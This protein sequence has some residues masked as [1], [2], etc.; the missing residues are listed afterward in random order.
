MPQPAFVAAVDFGGTKMAVAGATLNGEIIDQRRLKTQ[1]ARGAEQ[2]VE[3][4][5]EA[6]RAVIEH[7]HRNTGGR[8]VSLG[9]VCPGIVRSD[10][11]MLA[12][13][14]PGWE[15]LA[16]A[17]IMREALGIECVAVCNDV[18]AA[19]LAEL[20]WGALAGADPALFVSL[21][22]GVAA[23]VLVGGRILH[24]AH[25]AAGEI[26]YSLRCVDDAGAFADGHAPLEELAGGRFIGARASMLTGATMT[27]AAAFAARDPLTRELVDV[28]LDELAVHLANTA[29]VLDPQRI[30][31]GGGMMASADRVLAA[32]ER[33]L[34][35]AV[36]FPPELVPARFL[37]DSA[38]RGAIALAVD[39]VR[40][41]DR[42]AHA[43]SSL[44]GATR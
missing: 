28:A 2:A 20:R 4:G 23:A 19:G 37:H 8:C 6:A 34:R 15:E 29:I 44:A 31:V 1:A 5:I 24:G 32:I 40:A 7:T 35:Q 33:R 36:P 18:K 42:S 27:S 22:T 11:I 14:V 10:R 30:A 21:G 26:G 3:R 41:D 39:A 38:L 43:D 16:L 25:G 9:V 12:P 17:P 13:N